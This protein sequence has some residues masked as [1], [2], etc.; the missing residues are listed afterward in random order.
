MATHVLF[1]HVRIFPHDGLLYAQPWATDGGVEGEAD[2]D[3]MGILARLA[4]V[5]P[6]PHCFIVTKAAAPSLRYD[7][8]PVRG[9][10]K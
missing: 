10:K 1:T 6:K 2:L 9:H 7:K 8:E 5:M 4:L 3:E